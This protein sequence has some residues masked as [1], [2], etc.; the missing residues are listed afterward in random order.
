LASDFIFDIFDIAE[1]ELLPEA[2]LLDP[3]PALS[4]GEAGA[5]AVLL[6]F[7]FDAVESAGLRLQPST[8]KQ[9]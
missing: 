9:R 7:E 4:L 3:E 1:P 2:E 6:S 8:T 5:F